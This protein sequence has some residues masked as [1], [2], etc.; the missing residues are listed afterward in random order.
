VLCLPDVLACD[1]VV[2]GP[3][4]QMRAEGDVPDAEFLA[5]LAD[6]GLPV[7]LAWFQ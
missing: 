1:G 5:Q 3:G 6:D 7:G 4:C 2:F